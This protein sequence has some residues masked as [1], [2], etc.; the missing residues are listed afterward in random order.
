MV[1]FSARGMAL[2]RGRAKINEL[3]CR[4]MEQVLSFIFLCGTGVACYWFFF[5]CIGWFEKI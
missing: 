1:V 3:I 2:V 4:I 5:K